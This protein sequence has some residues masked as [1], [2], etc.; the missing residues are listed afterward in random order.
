MMLTAPVDELT[1]LADDDL[2]ALLVIR[3]FERRLLELF[4]EGQLSGTTH[5]CLGQEY[6]PVALA[7]LLEPADVVVSNHRGHGHYL[8]RYDDAAGLL[9]EIM[10]REGG[11]CQGVGGSQHLHRE[12]FLTSGV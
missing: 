9:A 5:T 8:A 3:H 10:G 12:G 4:D 11:L 2:G 1:E 7:P 6:V